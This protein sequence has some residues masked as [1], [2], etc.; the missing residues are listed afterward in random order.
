MH[1]FCSQLAVFPPPISELKAIPLFVR[2]QVASGLKALLMLSVTHSAC[3][4]GL[5]LSRYL[6]TL[7]SVNFTFLVLLD[8][9]AVPE[10]VEV[11]AKVT[12]ERKS[13]V[14]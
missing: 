1:R 5:S 13:Q 9:A 11:A 12:A 4:P 8:V 3:V 7:T 6:C 14:E 10:V 2:S